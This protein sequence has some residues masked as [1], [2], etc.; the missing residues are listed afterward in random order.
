MKKEFHEKFMFQA[1]KK[2]EEGVAA[3]QT[4]FGACIVTDGRII[5]CEHNIVWAESDITAH[6]KITAI[7]KACLALGEI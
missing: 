2:A 6:A 3:G 4:P 5:S 1:I 7:R